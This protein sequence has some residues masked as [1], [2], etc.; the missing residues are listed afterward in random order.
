MKQNAVHLM[1][2]VTCGIN[3]N[4]KN[5]ENG[6]K[7]KKVILKNLV[8]IGI[9][10]FYN[11]KTCFIIKGSTNHVNSDDSFILK[12]LSFNILAQNLLESNMYLYKN[13][14]KKYLPW[15][16]RKPLIIEEILEADAHVN[17]YFQLKRL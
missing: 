13:H 17:I 14:D 10:L 3:P 15:E 4:T 7:S 2:K 16:N 12:I 1:K 11:I 9:S 6:K 8:S 5:L